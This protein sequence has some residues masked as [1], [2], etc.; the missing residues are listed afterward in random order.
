MKKKIKI[1]KS[2]AYHSSERA[3]YRSL[4][5]RIHVRTNVK[6]QTRHL[7]TKLEDS[8]LKTKKYLKL[9]SDLNVER[10]IFSF[11]KRNYKSGIRV[12]Q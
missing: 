1:Q 8:K 10:N 3:P 9:L 2:N 6:M 7:A 11:F 12:V 4:A 5:N